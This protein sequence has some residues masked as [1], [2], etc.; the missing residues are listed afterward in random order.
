M[1]V[2]EVNAIGHA[3]GGRDVP[4]DD[5]R[6]GSSAKIE[7]DPNQFNVIR[8]PSFREITHYQKI[9]ALTERDRLMKEI[10]AVWTP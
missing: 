3:G 2:F 4:E 7:L 9:V 10:D 1:D 8:Y 5:N 6:E